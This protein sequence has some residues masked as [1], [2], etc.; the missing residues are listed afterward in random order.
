MLSCLSAENQAEYKEMENAKISD[1]KA[2]LLKWDVTV[3]GDPG[4][5]ALLEKLF[6]LFFNGA[7]SEKCIKKIT[8]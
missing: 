5:E 6:L 2:A 7:L 8:A 4:K 1:V 3:D